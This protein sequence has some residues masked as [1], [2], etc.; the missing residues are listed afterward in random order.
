MMVLESNL[1]KIWTAYVP[2]LKLAEA[3]SSPDYLDF[4]LENLETP[5]G[6]DIISLE[7]SKDR[8]EDRTH[9]RQVRHWQDTFLIGNI[10]IHYGD[11][12]LVIV[13]RYK[14]DEGKVVWYSADQQSESRGIPK[15][16]YDMTMI[17]NPRVKPDWQE[18]STHH[19]RDYRFHESDFGRITALLD[20][21]KGKYSSKERG[22]F[23]RDEERVMEYHKR[24]NLQ[25]VMEDP[26]Y[27]DLEADEALRIARTLSSHLCPEPPAQLLKLGLD[28]REAR[29]D[30]YGILPFSEARYLDHISQVRFRFDD[31]G[32]PGGVDDFLL[33]MD[34]ELDLES[35]QC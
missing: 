32:E 15:F 3:A 28:N 7:K 4:D 35:R 31:L 17:F 27:Q 29:P 14:F 20:D 23:L 2:M 10:Q 18:D 25:A 21:G 9:M 19:C 22:A 6:L 34:I 5:D 12:S 13:P 8:E 26:M 33:H 1:R 16:V 30:E 24:R 11:K